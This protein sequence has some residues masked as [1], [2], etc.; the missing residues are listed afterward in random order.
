MSQSLRKDAEFVSSARSIHEEMMIV[1]QPDESDNDDDNEDADDQHVCTTTTRP[2]STPQLLREELPQSETV[3]DLVVPVV[4]RPAAPLQPSAVFDDDMIAPAV[5]QRPAA[6]PMQLQQRPLANMAGA[7]SVDNNVRSLVHLY[8]S[9][10]FVPEP[11]T[12]MMTVPRTRSLLHIPP[13]VT[14]TDEDD[15]SSSPAKSAADLMEPNYDNHNHNE[16]PIGNRRLTRSCNSLVSGGGE[17]KRRSFMQEGAFSSAVAALKAAGF[18]MTGPDED[19]R[20][21]AMIWQ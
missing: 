14:V 7:L 3:D 21:S 16:P 5:V 13:L 19:A 1:D 2:L 9:M 17:E 15:P 20:R 18:Q 6:P 4:Q 10:L 12:M 8:E 11:V